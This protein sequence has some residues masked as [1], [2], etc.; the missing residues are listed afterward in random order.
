M[1]DGSYVYTATDLSIPGVNGLDLTI[2]RRFDS[3]FSNVSI[4]VGSATGFWPDD[5]TVYVD[6][7]G[8][9]LDSDG[10]G[11]QIA[12]LSDYTIMDTES[13]DF[14]RNDPRLFQSKDYVAAVRFGARWKRKSAV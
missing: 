10:T 6:Y 13:A 8:Y 14:V 7:I 3:S 11:I 2:T 5:Y 9:E 1:A 12:D 4:P